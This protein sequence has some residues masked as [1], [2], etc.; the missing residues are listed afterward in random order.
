M[1]KDDTAN[2]EAI[3]EIISRFRAD[4]KLFHLRANKKLSNWIDD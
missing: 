4:L 1:F 3:L 2:A